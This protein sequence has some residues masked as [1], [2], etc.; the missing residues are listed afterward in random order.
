MSLKL[1]FAN[2]EHYKMSVNV[3]NKTET[4]TIPSIS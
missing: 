1:V 2:L 3:R 4:C